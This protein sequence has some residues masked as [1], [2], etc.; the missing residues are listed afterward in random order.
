MENHSI[1]LEGVVETVL[2]RNAENGYIVLD[3]N[4]NDSMITVVGELGDLEEGERLSLDGEFTSHPKFGEQFRAYYCER[5]LPADALNIQR[6]LSSG[7]I[8]GIGPSLARK[9]VEAFGDRTLE[10]MEKEPTRLMEIRGISPKKCESIAQ[11]VQQIFALRSIM[12]FLSA[13][14]IASKYA[15]RAYKKW[16]AGTIEMVSANP[17]LLCTSGVELDFHKVEALAKDMH[18]DPDSPQRIAAGIVFILQHNTQ[19]GF[20]CLPLDRLQPKVCE[21]LNVSESAFYDAYQ[22]A[23][24]EQVIVEYCKREREFVYLADYYRAERYIADRITVIQDF[25][26]PEDNE[27][28]RSRIC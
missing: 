6:Y 1:H 21:C 8:K 24:N 3:L 5:T 13:Y 7:A 26:S 16:G 19:N 23:R 12:T 9:I 28:Y 4:A 14:G 22:E 17:Y 11:E 27:K 20:T 15:M 18:L 25:S 2:F 10:I